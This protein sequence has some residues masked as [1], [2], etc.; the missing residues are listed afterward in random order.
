MAC[1]LLHLPQLRLRS[2][3]RT[4]RLLTNRL[5]LIRRRRARL[6][7]KIHHRYLRS[8]PKNRRRFPK[9]GNHR[10]TIPRNG[11]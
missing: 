5:P 11:L 3:L 7:K 6:Q 1:R 2:L 9:N 4:R 10:K 8:V